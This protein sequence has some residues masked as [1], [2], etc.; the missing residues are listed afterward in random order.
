MPYFNIS[1]S[2][3]PSYF[4]GDW[5]GWISTFIPAVLMCILSLGFAYP[6]ARCFFLSWKLNS[7]VIENK[8]LSFNGIWKDLY[9]I[10]IKGCLLTIITCGIYFPIFYCQLRNWEYSKT[11]F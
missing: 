8:R 2:K 1:G 5:L 3:Y 4:D 6:Y 9:P 11:S 10:W 7:I